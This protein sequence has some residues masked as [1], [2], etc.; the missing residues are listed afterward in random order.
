MSKEKRF[1]WVQSY[2]WDYPTHKCSGFIVIARSKRQAQ[3]IYRKY[4]VA[5]ACF[6]NYELVNGYCPD[7]TH[8]CVMLHE[9]NMDE[10]KYGVDGI[11]C[12]EGI[13]PTD[14]FTGWKYS[15]VNQQQNK[16]KEDK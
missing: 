3:N 8:Q 15:G 1:F 14:E 13:I 7:K 6:D 9:G 5:T 11:L 12:K 10:L 2:D 4:V 16:A